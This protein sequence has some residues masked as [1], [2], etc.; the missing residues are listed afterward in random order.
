MLMEISLATERI[1]FSPSIRL[2]PTLMFELHTLDDDADPSRSYNHPNPK[3]GKLILESVFD[4]ERATAN[5]GDIV[6]LCFVTGRVV[7]ISPNTRSVE[8]FQFP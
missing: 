1:P 5:G 2:Y 7:I 8:T 4:H 6:S 3:G